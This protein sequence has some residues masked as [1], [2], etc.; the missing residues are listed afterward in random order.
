LS[1]FLA[2]ICNF[3]CQNKHLDLFVDSKKVCL[4]STRD[5]NSEQCLSKS[6]CKKKGV[7]HFRE[8]AV[9]EWIF[10][11]IWL[12][13]FSVWLLSLWNVILFFLDYRPNNLIIRVPLRFNEA[14]A[15][16]VQ[17]AAIEERERERGREKASRPIC[18]GWMNVWMNEWMNEWMN[19]RT[20]IHIRAK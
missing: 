3:G 1:N 20:G 11:Q 9:G 19:M 12:V 16:I 5:E 7:S 17:I 13:V 18:A 8:C 15:A 10:G 14:I 6:W 2:N 4:M